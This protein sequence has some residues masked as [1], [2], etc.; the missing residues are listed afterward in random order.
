MS[1]F[2]THITK[3]HKLSKIS[4]LF[5]S[6]C[7][8]SMIS[9]E[10]E[11]KQHCR[12]CEKSSNVKVSK[13]SVTCEICQKTCP[14]LQSFSVHMMF[15]KSTDTKSAPKTKWQRRMKKGVFICETCGKEFEY[16]R[17]LSHHIKR[18]HRLI[19]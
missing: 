3:L 13:H 17:Y 16:S 8:L 10:Q 6:V 2:N 1:G 18:L 14:N 5:C 7:K 9:T 12:L 15:H 4:R 19:N 11:F